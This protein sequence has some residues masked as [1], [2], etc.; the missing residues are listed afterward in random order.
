MARFMNG[1]EQ[2]AREANRLK[3]DSEMDKLLHAGGRWTEAETPADLLA[4]LWVERARAPEPAAA[5][6]EKLA[7]KVYLVMAVTT[8]LTFATLMTGYQ[9]LIARHPFA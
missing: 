5:R 6:P 3:R 4:G 8:L 7:F 2:A 9:M 1:S